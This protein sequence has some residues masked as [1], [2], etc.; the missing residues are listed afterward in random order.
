VRNVWILLVPRDFFAFAA[1]SPR[2]SL[3]FP[4]IVAIV[5]IVLLMALIV[6]W[7]LQSVFGALAGVGSAGFQWTMLSVGTAVITLVL[8]GVVF[9]LVLVV[10]TVNLNRR[11]SN[12]IDSV[13]HEL[14]SPIAS[15][16]LYLQTLSRR[17][18]SA[19]EQVGFY[20]FMLE[21]LD[22]LDHLINQ[23][24]D[25]ARLDSKPDDV[26]LEDV[27]LGALVGQIAQAVCVSY[28]VP[29]DTVQVDAAACRVRSRRG[30]LDLVFRNLID[31][32]VKYGGPKPRVEVT[33]RPAGDGCVTARIADNGP[34]IPRQARRK[35]FRRFVRLGVELEREKPGTGLGL[36]IVRT[37]VRRLGGR[38]RV[39]DREPAPGTVFEVRLPG[40]RAE[41]SG[42]GP[43]PAHRPIE[44]RVSSD[45]P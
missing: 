27:D 1:M 17:R 44:D 10:K 38:V 29:G 43:P 28:R 13:T 24:L 6:G 34:G 36:Y 25:A 15:L 20:R 26:D 4:I 2:R 19:D 37:L 8:V 22:R 11:Q 7:V 32:A 21:D 5:M 40:R 39:S 31:N 9:Y 12:F 14:K 30:D 18:V 33:L 3:R 16:K 45:S 41:P 23:V 35:V 42:E